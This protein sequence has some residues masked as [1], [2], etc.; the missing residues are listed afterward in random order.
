MR[1]AST[2]TKRIMQRK[3]KGRS[4]VRSFFS[5]EEGTISCSIHHFQCMLFICCVAM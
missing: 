4:D 1:L 2:K 3:R 5:L